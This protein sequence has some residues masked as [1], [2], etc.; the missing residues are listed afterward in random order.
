MWRETYLELS[1]K[2]ESAEDTHGDKVLAGR[3]T[4]IQTLFSIK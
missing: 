3:T 2:C 1:P 4:H